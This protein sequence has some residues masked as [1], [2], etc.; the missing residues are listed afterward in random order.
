MALNSQLKR[1]SYRKGKE[2]VQ[3]QWQQ[4]LWNIHLKWNQRTMKKGAG[5]KGKPLNKDHFTWVKQGTE[6]VTWRVTHVQLVKT[7]LQPHKIIS[8]T[9]K[10][11]ELAVLKQKPSTRKQQ[12]LHH[13]DMRALFYR[14]TATDN[15]SKPHTFKTVDV[16]TFTLPTERSNFTLDLYL[17]RWI[18]HQE[19]HNQS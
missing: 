15:Y 4:Q 5:N 16:I 8:S 10:H 18:T 9:T 6:H 2:R 1:D 17:K 7:I 11:L 3:W 19:E 13:K 12:R 14:Y